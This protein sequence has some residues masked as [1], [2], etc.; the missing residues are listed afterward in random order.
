M[1]PLNE[2][3]FGKTNSI[4]AIEDLISKFRLCY[5]I[6]DIVH[7]LKEFRQASAD[8]ILKKIAQYL[9]NAFGFADASVIIVRDPVQNAYTMSFIIDSIDKHGNLVMS[10]TARLTDDVY[11]NSII[12]SNRGFKFNDSKIQVGFLVC[13]NTGLILSKILTSAEITAILLHEIGHSFS[14]ILVKKELL[15]PRAD[16]SFADKFVSMYGYSVELSSVLQKIYIGNKK[17]SLYDV[18]V[19]NIVIGTTDIIKNIFEKEIM[20]EEHPGIK[21]RIESQIKMME[22]TLKDNEASLTPRMK[23]E[24]KNKIEE[25]KK[26]EKD[27]FDSTNDNAYYKMKKRYWDSIEP[28]LPANKNADIFANKGTDPHR[29]NTQLDRMYKKRGYFS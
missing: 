22:A 25:C 29:L 7:N 2:I 9:C 13:I 23:K 4:L 11:K 20:R 27:F 14:K 5:G 1:V 10:K 26:L 6:K 24:L 18:P 28:N 16:E 15:S 17:K 8:P 3:Y 21:Q 19:L 12:V